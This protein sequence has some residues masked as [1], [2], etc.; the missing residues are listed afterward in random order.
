M[1][2]TNYFL[3]CSHSFLNWRKH[4]VSIWFPIRPDRTLSSIR[5]TSPSRTTDNLA[6]V[7]T[8]PYSCRIERRFSPADYPISNLI[9][10]GFGN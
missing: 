6:I 9:T 5:V 4:G 2:F 10:I 8:E 1:S 7:E 3:M